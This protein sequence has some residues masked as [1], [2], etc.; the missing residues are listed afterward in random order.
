M[1]I[2]IILVL[3]WLAPSPPI[4]RTQ[5]CCTINVVHGAIFRGDKLNQTR[6]GVDTS[7]LG[8]ILDFVI[9]PVCRSFFIYLHTV[10]SFTYHFIYSTNIVEQTLMRTK[11]PWP[12]SMGGEV[13]NVPFVQIV[14]ILCTLNL[15]LTD[16]G[17]RG[18]NT[19]KSAKNTE[20][21]ANTNHACFICAVRA[22]DSWLSYRGSTDGQS[23][24]QRSKFSLNSAHQDSRS[25][26]RQEACTHRL[27]ETDRGWCE[28][29][30]TL[31]P[32]CFC[33]WDWQHGGK[34]Q[35]YAFKLERTWK[36]PMATQSQARKKHMHPTWV[37]YSQ[38][39][40]VLGYS[41]QGE[42]LISGKI[43]MDNPT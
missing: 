11:S 20:K 41:S 13:A 14:D 31:R 19:G 16:L 21:L 12:Y 39:V 9:N 35:W 8:K 33:H 4:G 15:L 29:P 6:V 1:L 34:G 40:A 42:V 2:I 3:C 22:K 18:K 26:I 37:W 27:A 17:N 10:F 38:E 23:I 24:N 5:S 30:W 25:A 32:D 28:C 43:Y 36:Q 7:I